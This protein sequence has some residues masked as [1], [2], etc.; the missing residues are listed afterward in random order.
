[1]G[2]FYA[3][4]HDLIAA[5]EPN[6]FLAEYAWHSDGCGQ[7]CATEPLMI[8]EILS[9]GGQIFEQSVPE[10]EKDVE[11]PEVTDK[12][13]EELKAMLEVEGLTAKD[14]I[15]KKKQFE[16]DRKTVAVRKALVARHK[17]VLSRLH[18]RYDTKNLPH[19]PKIGP[20]PG[21]VQGGI[22]IPKGK[23]G[24]VPT[25]VKQ[26]SPNKFQVRYNH[27]HPLNIVLKCDNPERWKWGK[28]PRTY[29]GL[30]KIWQAED[31]TRKDRQQIKPAAVVRTPISF[32]GL[33][34]APVDAG[35]E[36]GADAGT[37]TSDESSSCGCKLVGSPLHESSSWLL[38]LALGALI[39]RRRRHS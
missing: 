35:S 5:K 38:P 6:A 22:W 9:L 29:R 2:E 31:L 17:Y 39:R 18:Y 37:V 23:K 21:A 10:A 25:E 11:P 8:H 19:D 28:A 27:F 3:A 13:K 4:L 7:P 32:L 26:T 1:M 14:K 36:A 24:E 20:T 15:D 16:T 30:R 34:A 33:K 12:E